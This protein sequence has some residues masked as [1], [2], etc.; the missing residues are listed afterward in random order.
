[1]VDE[2]LLETQELINVNMGGAQTLEVGSFRISY[3]IKRHPDKGITE[4]SVGI[5]VID[6]DTAVLAVADGFGGQRCGEVAS[7]IAIQSIGEALHSKEQQSLRDKICSAFEKANEAILHLGVGAATTL[8]V[9]ELCRGRIRF[10]N[11]GD[12]SCLLVGGRGRIKVTTVQHNL[13]GLGQQAGLIGSNTRA[14]RDRSNE[15]ANYLGS[16]DLR[17]ETTAQKGVARLDRT[18]LVSDGILDNFDLFRKLEVKSGSIM[19]QE[20]ADEAVSCMQ[21]D[22][23]KVDD[24]SIVV[25]EYLHAS[26]KLL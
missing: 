1:M 8:T 21:T 5:F 19:C 6:P 2:K 9:A 13:I 4:D 23:G 14:F 15:V 25:L 18:I 26:L 3:F 20:I 22:R 7:K 10:Y 24:L 16:D 11:A 12:S 17:I